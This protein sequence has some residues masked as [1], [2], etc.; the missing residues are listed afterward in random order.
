MPEERRQNLAETDRGSYYNEG[1]WLGDKGVFY[2]GSESDDGENDGGNY[3]IFV[4]HCMAHPIYIWECNSLVGQGRCFIWIS[5]NNTINLY[6][7]HLCFANFVNRHSLSDWMGFEVVV[8]QVLRRS[9]F[10]SE[11]L[12]SFGFSHGLLLLHSQ[13]FRLSSVLMTLF[14]SFTSSLKKPI[15]LLRI[16]TGK[17]HPKIK[18]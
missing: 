5:L 13:E 15:S 17:K 10:I 4:I 14:F 7:V 8:T 2:D 9:S 16:L 18:L 3:I 1:E 6:I 11:M 12:A